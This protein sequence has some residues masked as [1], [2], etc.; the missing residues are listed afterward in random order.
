MSIIRTAKW[1]FPSL[2]LALSLSACNTNPTAGKTQAKTSEAVSPAPAPAPT[3]VTSTIP[4]TKASGS[5]GFVGA[6]VTDKHEGSFGDYSGSITVVDSSVEKSSVT[7]KIEMKSLS[8]EPEKLK[9]HLMSADL[10]DVEK[11]P[12]A[13]FSSTK[14]APAEGGKYQVTGNLTLHGVT[15]SIVFPATIALSPEGAAVSAEFGI[16]RKDF[17]IVYPGMPDDLIKDDVLIKLDLK[18]KKD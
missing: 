4:L 12:T 16:N 8:V 13:E 6:K 14:I 9:G 1:T 15:K 17:G 3:S 2:A 11:F 10:F 18:A 7:V 5:I